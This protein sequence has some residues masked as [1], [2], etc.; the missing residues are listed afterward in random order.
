MQGRV[1]WK[2][3]VH[4]RNARQRVLQLFVGCHSK[5]ALHPNVNCSFEN[6]LT[7]DLSVKPDAVPLSAERSKLVESGGL[8]RR[9]ENSLLL[10]LRRVRGRMVLRCGP[11]TV[12]AAVLTRV[13][14]AGGYCP[15]G[16]SSS[17]SGT[18][19]DYAGP[20]SMYPGVESSPYGLL[21]SGIPDRDAVRGGRGL[22][23]GLRLG[24]GNG[25]HLVHWSDWRGSTNWGAAGRISADQGGGGGLGAPSLPA[26]PRSGSLGTGR[27]RSTPPGPRPLR[28]NHPRPRG[29]CPVRSLWP[30]TASTSARRLPLPEEQAR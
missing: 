2:A 10:Q 19:P 9:F 8:P 28:P 11:S 1:T 13:T 3:E 18:S 24:T 29:R 12:T 7:N 4:L 30:G 27:P 5:L 23:G 20:L 17:L 6:M 26:T 21:S 14:C 16:A 22:G 25:D 15:P